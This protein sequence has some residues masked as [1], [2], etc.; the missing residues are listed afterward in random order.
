V[1]PIGLRRMCRESVVGSAEMCLV[2]MSVPL[3]RRLLD[4][5]ILFL[6]YRWLNSFALRLSPACPGAQLPK[7]D[8][9]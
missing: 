7:T 8:R 4:C 3:R 1:R 6:A 2:V 5:A 9:R